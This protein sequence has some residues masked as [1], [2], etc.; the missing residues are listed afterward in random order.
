M[1]VLGTYAVVQYIVAPAWDMQWLAESGM[2]SSM[3]QPE[4]TEFRIFGT[5]NATGP[6]AKIMMVG[7]LLLF[8]G[9]GLIP[10]LAAIP[11]Y[12]SLLL[13]LVRAAW[14]GWLVGVAFIVSRL[15]GKL[16]VRLL[17]VLAVGVALAI[18]LLLYAPNTER[19]A[20]RA[21]SLTNLDDDGSLN[22]RMQLYRS[23]TAEALLNPVGQGIGSF[24][25]A[26]K[27]SEGE[28]VS[29][30]SGVLAIPF[31]LGWP[32]TLLYIGGLVWMLLRA[33]QIRKPE[34][35]QFAVIA[36]AIVLAYM[37]MMVFHNQLK[38]LSG[39]TV[40][41]FLALALAARRYYERVPDRAQ[42]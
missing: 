10:R 28:P 20:T 12:A 32:G 18:P 3:G 37:A 29:F 36:V 23:T 40:W 14:G 15:T 8:D 24:G 35:D 1:L 6:F 7:L 2:V 16:R 5:L 42:A 11:G 13:T 22:A 27:L 26:A 33:L 9:R 21:E 41:S 31:T 19:V 30:D 38:G 39:V 4:P 25:T 34:T 17:F